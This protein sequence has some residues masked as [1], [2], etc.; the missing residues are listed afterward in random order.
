MEYITNSKEID[1]I[2]EVNDKTGIFKK[3]IL[4]EHVQKAKKGGFKQHIWGVYVLSAWIKR[5]LL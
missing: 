5:W 3:E 1:I 2:G 4:E